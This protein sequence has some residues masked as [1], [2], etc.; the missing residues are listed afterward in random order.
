MIKNQDYLFSETSKEFKKAQ[1]N[2]LLADINNNPYMPEDPH[3]S[4]NK[5]LN[6]TKKNVIGAI[7]EA[8][9]MASEAYDKMQNI[10]G[11][12]YVQSVN[13]S[14]PDSEGNVV[15]D[16]ASKA[17]NDARGRRID[18]TYATV[19]EIESLKSQTVS[20]INGIRPDGNGNALLD[21]VETA[22]KSFRDGS[23]N[24]ITATYVKKTE[25][26][27]YIVKNDMDKFRREV[28]TENDKQ[29]AKM[30]ENFAL[31]TD[32]DRYVMKMEVIMNYASKKDLSAA[33][34]EIYTVIDN[35]YINREDAS[36]YA[37]LDDID[38]YYI[39]NVEKKFDNCVTSVNGIK[40]IDAKAGAIKITEVEKAKNDYLGNRIDETYATK[41]ELSAE[42]HRADMTYVYQS[43]M[44]QYVTNKQ[45]QN[46]GFLYRDEANNSYA[47]KKT[48]Q[49]D[50]ESLKET[51]KS[52]TAR[53]E[54]LE[55]KETGANS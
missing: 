1:S 12:K 50:I 27:D 6:T 38:D 30:K 43:S 46:I 48:T 24:I 14:K 36:R 15:I 20:S 4:Q 37:L 19:D 44:G 32:L 2:I 34:E 40:A 17:E 47:D 13:G 53:I 22:T 11:G 35:K 41:A 52:L 39:K 5:N 28:L 25:L 23:N 21:K 10:A 29:Y 33:K 45:L 54:E 9:Y 7:D 55:K 51:I 16:S 49:D 3:I 42:A 8:F 18:Q 31:V 26:S